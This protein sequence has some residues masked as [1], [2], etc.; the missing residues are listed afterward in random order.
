M[1]PTQS[2]AALRSA[3]AE[4]IVLFETIDDGR[5]LQRIRDGG[6]CIRQVVGHLIDSA[7]NNHR[8]FVLGQSADLAKYDGYEQD[9]WVT[10]QC[11][12]TAAWPDLVAL[13]VAY[14]HHLMHVMACTP[15]DAASRTAL[16]PDGQSSVT[17]AFLMEDYVVHL[18]HH[19]EQIR[20]LA[21]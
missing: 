4:A 1:T 10:R 8:R 12:D 13:W 11:Y 18:R 16:A 15:T 3:M 2:A 14:N 19:L 6:W 17:L 9:A 20:A 7:C 21:G 5:S